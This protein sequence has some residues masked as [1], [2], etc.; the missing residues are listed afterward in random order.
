MSRFAHLSEDEIQRILEDKDSTKYKTSNKVGKGHIF[1]IEKNVEE[2]DQNT[3]LGKILRTFYLEARKRDGSQ[4]SMGSL[5]TIHFGLCR[6]FKASK[7]TH[8]K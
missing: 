6:H 8:C 2:P 1:S 5:K 4:Y 3:E 7:S